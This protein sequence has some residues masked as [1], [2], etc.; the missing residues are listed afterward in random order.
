MSDL[1]VKLIPVEG[2]RGLKTLGPPPMVIEELIPV[3]SITLVSGQPYS[4]KTFFA[5]EAA[6]AVATGSLFMGKWKVERPGNVLIVEQDSPKYDTGRALWAMLAEQAA[7]EDPALVEDEGSIVDPIYT[8]W[9]PGLDL[10]SR[11]DALRIAATANSLHTWRGLRDYPYAA[12][13]NEGNVTHEWEEIDD[14]YYGVSLIILDSSRSLHRGEEN[15]SGDMEQVLQNI[16][17]IR[18][19]TGAAIILIA[20]DNAAGEKTRG[21]TAIPAGVDTEYAVTKRRRN[22]DH[23]VF[24]RKARAIAP[25][26]FRYTITT[27]AGD[28]G[29]TKSVEFKEY[30]E[31]A[32]EEQPEE[33]GKREVLMRFIASGPKELKRDLEPWSLAENVSA[34]TLKTYLGDAVQTGYLTVTYRQEG[35][36]RFAVY[37]VKG[38][39]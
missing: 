9:H 14:G 38:A 7:A 19:K 4:G 29:V 15:E 18:E 3:G 35:R 39:V 8:A 36:S 30:I 21:S 26:E 33:E 2:T 34:R 37:A 1:K 31:E 25:Q 20:H 17:L 27:A 22:K 24:I 28:A 23:G 12:V 13:D 32:V 10:S 11:L 5:L 6:R 16:K